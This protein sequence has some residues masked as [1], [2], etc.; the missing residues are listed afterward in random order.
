[1]HSQT[2]HK[3]PAVCECICTVYTCMNF[4]K[5]PLNSYN[6][7]MW[8]FSLFCHFSSRNGEAYR[9]FQ[10][11]AAILFTLITQK[12]SYSTQ[13]SIELKTDQKQTGDSALV[14]S[15]GMNTIYINSMRI[16]KYTLRLKTVQILTH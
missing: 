7:S 10:L 15:N 4:W 6:S 12:S 8:I 3:R 14:Q 2:L 9:S 16:T 11:A 13:K 1:M 5:E